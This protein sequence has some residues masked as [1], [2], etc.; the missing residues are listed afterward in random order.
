M[1]GRPSKEANG[2]ESSNR[3]SKVHAPYS[4]DKSIEFFKGVEGLLAGF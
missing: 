3:S 2:F 4:T 1:G